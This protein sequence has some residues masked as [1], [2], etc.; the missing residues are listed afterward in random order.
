MWED[1]QIALPDGRQSET[2]LMIA[3]SV[4]RL[5]RARGARRCSRSAAAWAKRSKS[6]RRLAGAIGRSSKDRSAFA[7]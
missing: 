6:A 7:I 5:L 3:R 4:R 1:M 2:A